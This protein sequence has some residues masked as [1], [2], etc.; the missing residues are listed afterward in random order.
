MN[1]WRF[2]LA[3]FLT[4]LFFSFLSSAD[5]TKLFPGKVSTW[6]G[7]SMYSTKDTKVVVPK[8]IADGKPWIWR[9]RFWGH[10]PQFDLAMLAK[11]YHVVYCNVGNLFGSPQ[12][13]KK[14]DDF[15]TYL[16]FEHLLADR[17]IL[18][19]MSR[20]GLIIYNWAAKNPE[21]VA[22]IYGDAPVMDFKSWPGGKGQ[23]PGAASSW[24]VC[25][26][27]Y[28]FTEEQALAYKFNPIDNLKALA[29]AKIPIL[30]VVGDA[31]KV[32]PVAE[33]TAIAEKLYKKMGGTFEVIH[34]PGIG[35]VHSL[36]DPT[37]IVDFMIKHTEKKATISAQD[38]VGDKNFITRSDFQNSRVQF[39]KNKKGHVAFL[40][41]SI[42][43]MNGYR[44]IMM[45]NLQKRFPNTTFNF[46]AAGI[47]ST[48]SDTGAFRLQRDI[49]SQGP[50]DM[51]FVEFAVN[52]DQDGIY[53]YNDALRGMEGII[54]QARRHNPN[55]DIVMTFFVNQNIL[56][57]AQKGEM[58]PST[59]AHS[60]V[61][62]H[63]QISVN[64]LAQELADLINAGKMD[65][66]RFGGVH[67]NKYGNTM[68]ATM[69][70]N[71][72]DK[73]WSKPLAKDAKIIAHAKQ[74]LLDPKSYSKG[75][76]L[77]YE[78]IEINQNWKKGVPDWKQENKGNVRTRFQQSPMIYTKKAGA[79]LKINFT[80]TAIG[81]YMLSGPDAGIIKCTIDGKE[82]RIIDTLHKH[83][84][85]NYPM[86]VMFFNELEDGE[87]T[88]EMETLANK[89]G[90]IKPGGS[91]FRAL[92]FTAN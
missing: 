31:D 38:I 54:A 21:K 87:H 89:P 86:T 51:L 58:N 63:H 11:G 49:L 44:P 20:G 50:L 56:Q 18:E 45:D 83:S 59:T 5:E 15:Y 25:L 78:D 62:E 84:G 55:V 53:S 2:P 3:F 72:F 60:K 57:K 46:T 17:A 81:A 66:K 6:H 9:A 91:A 40:G 36:K 29:K 39:E 43:E 70:Q 32:V 52:D 76:F 90:R 42:T 65:W 33:N 61:A 30:H 27:A 48:C 79:K 4:L 64:N 10:Q 1:H 85:F 24:K 69:I 14:W 13:V 80:G 77:A 16:R 35:H 92:Y 67:P 22:A 75:R 23:G 7:Y 34:K 73:Q 37:P 28:G 8:T 82:T 88:L 68:A 41:G 12:A 74:E 26:K 71:A 47:S 19:G